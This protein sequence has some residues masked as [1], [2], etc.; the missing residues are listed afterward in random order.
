MIRAKGLIRPRE[1]FRLL[2]VSYS[3]QMRRVNGR[4]RWMASPD[5]A[6]CAVPNPTVPGTYLFRPELVE[7]VRRG[8][9]IA[10]RVS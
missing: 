4:L 10:E 3:R 2:G 6:A 8:E 9:R 1:A 5:V 7:K